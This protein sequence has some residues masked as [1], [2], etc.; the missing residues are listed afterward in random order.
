MST[1]MIKG[2]LLVVALVAAFVAFVRFNEV[3]LP[4]GPVPVVWDGE[5]CAHCKMHVGDP[6]FAAQLQTTEGDV[7]NFD[8]PGCLFDYLQS[9]EVPVHALYFRNYDGDGWLPE[10]E[11]GFLTVEDSPMG[12]GIR[13]VP[14]DTPEAED[15]DWAEGRVMDR[16]HHQ[17]GGS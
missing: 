1:K 12:Y 7:L 6:R 2:L 16:P 14:K 13:A 8:D 10:S 3:M 11:A 15:I 17:P 9:H 4:E 5:V